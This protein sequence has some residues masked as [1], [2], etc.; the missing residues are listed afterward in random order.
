MIDYLEQGR[1]INGANYA[2]KLRQLSQEITRKRRGKLTYGVL[3]LQ[4][5]A[6]A[7]KLP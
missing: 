7:H 4:D 5:N 2:G 6:P 3:L 1:T